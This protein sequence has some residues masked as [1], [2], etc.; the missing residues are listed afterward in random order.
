MRRSLVLLLALLLTALAIGVV[1]PAASAAETGQIRVVVSTPAGVPASIDLAGPVTRAVAKPAAGRRTTVVL[2]VPVGQYQLTTQRSVVDGVLYTAFFSQPRLLA[3]TVTVSAGRVAQVT[4]VFVAPITASDVQATSIE[5]TSIALAW[6]SPADTTF[7][8]RRTRGT[9]PAVSPTDGVTVPVV[10]STATDGGLVPGTQYTY[11]LFP[12][13]LG[14]WGAPFVLQAGTA[15]PDGSTDASF[16]AA[17][18]TWIT[19]QADII[20]LAAVGENLQVALAPTV[21]TRVIGSVVVLPMSDALP[22]GFLGVVRAVSADGATVELAPGGLGDAFYRY[23]IDVPDVAAIAEGDASGGMATQ[24][25]VEETQATLEDEPPTEQQP[26]SPA[27]RAPMDETGAGHS[28]ASTSIATSSVGISCT[29]DVTTAIVEPSLSLGGVFTGLIETNRVFGVDVPTGKAAFEMEFKAELEVVVSVAANASGT[30]DL[31]V[32]PVTRQLTAYPVPLAAVFKPVA[33]LSYGAGVS[34]NSLGFR[35]T[36]GVR[37]GGTISGTGQTVTATPIATASLIQPQIAASGTLGLELGGSVAVGPGGAL[38]KVGAL[39]ALKGTLTVL[40]AEASLTV[41]A[42]P[43]GVQSCLQATAGWSTGLSLMARAWLGKWS[44]ERTF[45]HSALQTSGS[46]GSSPW[47]APANCD[48][49]PPPT[50]PSESVLGAGVSQVS[51]QSTGDPTQRGYVEGFVPGQRTWVVTSGLAA[52][53]PGVPDQFA[54]TSLGLPGDPVLDGLVDGV[55]YDAASYEV[56][57]RPTGSQLFVRYAFASEEYPEYV[58][59]QYNDVMAVLVDGQNCA[60]IPGGSTPV[61]INTVN[62]GSNS[63]YYVDNANGAAGYGTAMDG[64]TVPLTCAVPVVPGRP[65]SVRIAV[66]DVGDDGFDSAVALL[67]GGIWSA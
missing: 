5:Q 23:E 57:V 11:A 51:E 44:T 47:T 10:G 29:T 25:T 58:G 36:A 17:P 21:P 27:D 13:T 45:S 4:A 42:T 59:S 7:T 18:G 28:Q 64:L 39:A 48:V 49:G 43:A 6:R 1:A 9:V 19:D 50:V 15:P 31:T 62:V 60:L 65:V 8:V 20:S 66:A 22:G 32:P 34:T 16:L 63:A 3:T 24:A 53:V 55:T 61:S 41:V 40:D 37:V 38:G 46:Y 30:C 26:P 12:R 2:T 56:V 33:R 52:S 67:D 35:A 54:S 14:R